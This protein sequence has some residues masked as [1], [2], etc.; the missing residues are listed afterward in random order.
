MNPFLIGAYSC[1]GRL[2]AMLQIKLLIARLLWRYDVKLSDHQ[3]ENIN[4]DTSKD[5]GGGTS[6]NDYRLW[7][8]ITAT[9]EGPFIQVRRR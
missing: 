8:H 2:M 9:T 5:I 6:S 7:S 1:P 4:D 3:P